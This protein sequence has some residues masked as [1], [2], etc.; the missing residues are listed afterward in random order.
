M[1]NPATYRRVG[2]LVLT[3]LGWA[4]DADEPPQLEVDKFV[5]NECKTRATSGLLTGRETSDYAGL[6]CVAWDFASGDVAIDLINRPAHCG[7]S[8]EPS[9]DTLW[10]PSV[11]QLSASQIEYDVEWNFSDPNA[12]EG[13][14]HDFSVKLRDVELEERVRIDVATRSCTT[15]CPWERDSLRAAEPSGIR[16][17]YVDDGWFHGDEPGMLRLPRTMDVATASWC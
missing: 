15:I 13:C 16:C 9:E 12:C 11:R 4:C 10:S 1:S 17:R 7:F 3:V 5:L 14:L 2:I 8:G 6:E